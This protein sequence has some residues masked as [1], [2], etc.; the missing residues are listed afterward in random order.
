MLDRWIIDEWMKWVSFKR[1]VFNCAAD[2][3]LNYKPVQ[4]A[5]IQMAERAKVDLFI[6]FDCRS[7]PIVLLNLRARTGRI[8]TCSQGHCR[9]LLQQVLLE[10]D[11]GERNFIIQKDSENV[12]V[13]F[14]T[15]KLCY[16]WRTCT[17][18]GS[19]WL[20][21]SSP[22]SYSFRG[23]REEIIQLITPGFLH[24]R[25]ETVLLVCKPVNF[26]WKCCLRSYFL[27]LDGKIPAHR[28]CIRP[29]C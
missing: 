10:Q 20:K 9:Y 8:G 7:S 28:L 29:L 12:F 1:E 2:R 18:S 16:L 5:V 26:S 4:A 17:A 23:W 21:V 27:L 15:T 14:S 6:T 24:G 22:F 11:A 19:T 13:L 3:N 25:A